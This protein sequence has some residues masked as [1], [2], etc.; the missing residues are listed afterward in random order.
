MRK[1]YIVLSY[2]GTFLSKLIRIYTRKEYSHVSISLDPHLE[3]MYSFGRIHAYNPFWAGFVQESPKF[4]TFKRFKKSK[5]RIYSLEVSE[6]DYN[7][8]KE[9]IDNIRLHR[10]H[11]KY[12]FAGLITIIG[13]YHLKRE[14][15]FYCA[16][17]VKYVLNASNLELDLPEIVKPDDFQKLDGADIIYTGIISEY[18]SL[19]NV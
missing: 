10:K 13:H 2:T 3:N 4:G 16:E 5:I 11:Y 9:T 15:C 7:I 17:F 6:E 1:I 19:S 8:I 18:N 14:N 12:N